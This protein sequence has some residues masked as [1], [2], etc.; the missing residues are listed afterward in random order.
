MADRS[1]REPANTSVW[2]VR[3]HTVL[4]FFLAGAFV[5]GLPILFGWGW[6]LPLALV[7]VAAVLA[8]PSVWLLRKVS[9]AAAGR[10]YGAGWARAAAGWTLLLGALTAAPIYY[11][12]VVTDTRPATVPQVA[13]TNGEKRVV[14]QGMQHIGSE[15][16]YQ[17]VIYDVEKA[18]ADGYVIYY[19]GVQTSTPESKAFFEKLSRELVGGGD[20][21]G[22]YK[23]IGEVCG[24]TFQLD[25]F[26]LLEADKAEHPERHV[27][28]DVDAIELKA[29]YE[30]LMREDPTFAKAHADDF[31]PKPAANDNALM[32]RAV[33]WLKN[34]SESQKALGGVVCRGIFTLS[35]PTG[36]GP[37]GR[38]EPVILDFRNRALAQRI[39]QSP[40]ERIFITYGAAHLPG[41]FAE[42]QKLD[43]R[44]QVGSVK[45]LR[46]IEAPE[47]LEGRLQGVGN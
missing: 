41:L 24:M 8:V 37:P 18:L 31:R 30:R 45:W 47:H 42:L 15:H 39:V 26:V 36:D 19:E 27:V 12:A 3:L 32:L 21:S 4:W 22:T 38:M 25:Y 10:S 34:G 20:L 33:E 46:T 5:L 17:A 14:F 16:F 28:A 35:Q 9:T 13:L 43:P 6:W 40:E 2:R 23:S 29:E 1:P 7:V 11:L 44:W